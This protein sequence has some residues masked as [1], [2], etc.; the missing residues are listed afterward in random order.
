MAVLVYFYAQEKCD[1]G[2]TKKVYF[3]ASEYIHD[4]YSFQRAISS[5]R[6]GRK[7]MLP[8]LVITG[9]EVYQKTGTEEVVI[10]FVES[11][12][13]YAQAFGYSVPDD[14]RRLPGAGGE[15][16]QLLRRLAEPGGHDRRDPDGALRRLPLLHAVPL[17]PGG[18]P[19]GAQRRAPAGG[20]GGSRG[21]AG[22]A[23]PG[24]LH[25]PLPPGLLPAPGG[26]DGSLP[27][28]LLRRRLRL[29][30]RTEPPLPGGGRLGD[31]PLPGR[32][33]RRRPLLQA[34]LPGRRPV[35]LRA[36]A[37]PRQVPLRKNRMTQAP[38]G[39]PPGTF[40][41]SRKNFFDFFADRA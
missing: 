15:L 17:A 3:D 16:R 21:A 37:P 29:L 14:G 1:K 2:T 41:P 40:F 6:K 26:A 13:W 28:A 19:G 30:R 39:P 9:Q 32:G 25:G 20:R 35:A 31:G 5:L 4:I 23:L 18:P 8:S 22:A 10:P 33:R 12:D 36:A 34:L 7:L 38:G 27:G 24:P 11:D